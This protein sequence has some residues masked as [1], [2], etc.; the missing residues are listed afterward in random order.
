MISLF[1]VLSVYNFVLERS[2]DKVVLQGSNF[3]LI[4][5]V[6]IVFVLVIRVTTFN[7]FAVKKQESTLL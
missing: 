2:F 3:S 4:I 1:D 5:R 6:C 7:L